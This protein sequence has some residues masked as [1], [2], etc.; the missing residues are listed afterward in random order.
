MVVKIYMNKIGLPII[1][2]VH[3]Y[4][5]TILFPENVCFFF[6]SAAYIQVHFRLR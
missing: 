4:P 3:P 6:K 5:A 1:K 2:R